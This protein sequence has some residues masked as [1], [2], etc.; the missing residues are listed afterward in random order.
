MSENPHK[1]WQKFLAPLVGALVTALGAYA[2]AN[3]RGNGERI[4]VVE[5]RLNDVETLRNDVK[6]LSKNVYT[7]IGE[8][9]A[10][11]ASVPLNRERR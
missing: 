5:T 6:E 3:S 4:A 2:T 1:S 11:R 10:E 7:L 8:I 9:R